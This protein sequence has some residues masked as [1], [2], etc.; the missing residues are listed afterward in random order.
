M[1]PHIRSVI[2][3]D[4]AAIRDVPVDEPWEHIYGEDDIPVKAP[5][6]AT[7]LSSNK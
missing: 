3:L 1:V 7:V 4:D 6:Y 5:T 2:V